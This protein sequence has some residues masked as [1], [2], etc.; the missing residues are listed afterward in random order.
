MSSELRP[1][2]GIGV[3]ILNDTK[4]LLLGQRKGSLGEGDYAPP[5][6]HLEFGESFEEC[7]IRK[8]KEETGIVVVNPRFF[9]ITNDI[10]VDINKHYI[11]IFMQATLPKKQRV[12][13]M[14]PHKHTKWEWFDMDKLPIELFL[15]LK[16]LVSNQDIIKKVFECKK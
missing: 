10:F 2:V 16:N 1:K 9:S 15:P 7:A 12:E 6:G 13:N 3:L 11:S 4:Q 14:E 5:G 8:A